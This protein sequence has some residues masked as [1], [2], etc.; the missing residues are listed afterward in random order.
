MFIKSN[1]DFKN[2]SMNI[3]V[4]KKITQQIQECRKKSLTNLEKHLKLQG[5]TFLGGRGANKLT[6]ESSPEMYHHIQRAIF[7]SGDRLFS[8]KNDL[9]QDAIIELA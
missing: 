5:I 6:G 1:P 2:Q 8:H 9:M 4:P 7:F 3:K